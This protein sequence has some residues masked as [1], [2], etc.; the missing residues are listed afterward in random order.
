MRKSI[1]YILL[2]VFLVSSCDDQ[3]LNTTLVVR[4]D[5]D[6]KLTNAEYM[7]KFDETYSLW[8]ELL[9][10]AD[11]YNALNDAK[12][13]STV[14]APDNEAVREFLDWK[15]VSSVKELDREYARA[16]AEVHVLN[17]DLGEASFITYVEEGKIPILTIFGT[18]LSASYG[19]VKNDVDDSELTNEVFDQNK[20]FLN[21]Q[22]EVRDLG[23][24]RKTSN[25]EVYT[26]GGV[27]RPLT[28]TIIEKLRTY[29]NEYS[30]FIKAAEL[31]GFE[32]VANIYADTVY[33][34][35]GSMSV[36]D[37]R[38][39]CFAVPDEVYKSA[40]YSSAEAL[41]TGLGAGSDYTNKENE[42]YRYMSYHFLNRSMSKNEIFSFQEDGGINIYDTKYT[43]QVITARNING[44][45]LINDCA[46][47]IRSNI[48]S[49]NGMI[50]K[51]NHIMPVYEPEPVTVIWDF[52]NTSDIESFVNSYGASKN[53]GEMFSRPI[54]A[55]EYQIDLSDDR[56]EGDHGTLM[57]FAYQGNSTKTSTGSW[58]RIGFYKCAW[59]SSKEPEVNKYGAYMDNLM[60]LNLGYAGWIEMKTPT[61]IKGK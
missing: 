32:N 27:I 49:R 53:L 48:A 21:N 24:A 38:Y 33:N 55:K 16:V 12:T 31:T 7:K 36:N 45:N 11:F 51:I 61:I 54:D 59:L 58:R 28:E 15:G 5:D 43:H 34:L 56:R 50:H 23:R 13:K 44:Q 29:D 18:Y 39:T 10:H 40:G 1:L 22:A 52:L 47:F 57:S 3:F 30:I 35:D 42:L 14:F 17:Y 19:Y 9:K 4:D 20:I 8:I 60:I 25:G 41:A 2:S 26:L 46:S 6:T 37:I